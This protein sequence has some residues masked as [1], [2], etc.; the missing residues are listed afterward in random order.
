[1]LLGPPAQVLFFLI[2]SV[3]TRLDCFI[4]HLKRKSAPSTEQMDFIE[5][6][7]RRNEVEV[8]NLSFD[9]ALFQGS[10]NSNVDVSSALSSRTIPQRCQVWVRNSFLNHFCYVVIMSPFPWKIA[11]LS[12]LPPASPL[13]LRPILTTHLGEDAN[14]RE[15]S[16]LAWQNSLF[17]KYFY[18][19]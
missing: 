18:T 16:L 14:K 8:K 10:A 19:G 3:K 17:K 7:D 9:N 1:M 13:T 11:K 5:K 15:R 2:S 6:V 12:S 4:L